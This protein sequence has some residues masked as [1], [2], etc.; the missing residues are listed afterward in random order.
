MNPA[1]CRGSDQSGRRAGH[2]SSGRDM[3][4]SADRRWLRCLGVLI[5][6]LPLMGYLAAT[7]AIFGYAHSVQRIQAVRYCDVAWPPRWP[8]FKIARGDHYIARAA[9][10]VASGQRREA[11]FVVRKGVALSPANQGG[12][13]LFAELLVEGGQPNCA[14]DALIEG[15]IYQPP[16]PDYAARL[17]SLLLRQQEDLR[18]IELA[19]RQL[20]TAN[21]PEESAAVLALA[22]ATASHARGDFETAE[23]FFRWVPKLTDS[24]PGRLLA[25]RI[26]RDRGYGDL[27]LLHLRNL[28]ADFPH[29]PEIHADLTAE[30]QRSGR[31]TEALRATLAFQLAHPDRREPRLALI[32]SYLQVGDDARAHREAEAF[33]RDFA[34]DESALAALAEVG[35]NA[36]DLVLAPRLAEHAALPDSSQAARAILHV[37]AL[38]V[39]CDY[40]AAV[41]TAGELLRRHPQASAEFVSI[42]N[43]LLAVAN[44]GLHD[45]ETGRRLL[46]AYLEQPRLRAENLVALAQRLLAV[47]AVA[48]ARSALARAVAV[49]PRSQLALTRLTELDLNTDRFDDLL[50]NLA[51]LLAMRRPSPEVLRVAQFKLGSDRLLFAPQREAVL[52]A[53]REALKKSRAAGPRA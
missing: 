17:C 15:I 22:A 28:A 30:L 25:A 34:A 50:P 53:V 33:F 23:Q 20:T 1:A 40:Q 13:L 27:A 26:Q 7:A 29:D 18:V 21:W 16:G 5:L 24:R 36:G 9:Q 19:Q 44:F 14:R 43:G 47:D 4:P 35:A 10:M 32:R 3:M 52:Q 38:V 12:R 2:S 8:Q 39:A 46:T 31:T 49:E 6:A 42:I 37:E 11:L 41:S 45:Q 48:E 51:R